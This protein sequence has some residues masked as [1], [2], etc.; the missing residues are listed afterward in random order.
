MSCK[1]PECTN[2]KCTND[3]YCLKHSYLTTTDVDKIFDHMKKRLDKIFD[4]KN[5]L[6]E[7]RSMLR[8]AAY[9]SLKKYPLYKSDNS[10]IYLM[11][12]KKVFTNNILQK[13]F[14]NNIK[15]NNND[16]KRYSEIKSRFGNIFYDLPIEKF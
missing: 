8:L 15:L 2:C 9:L 7:F 4:A 10:H 1:I 6:Q 3:G 5:K 11:A 16:I 12:Y 14:I 13:A